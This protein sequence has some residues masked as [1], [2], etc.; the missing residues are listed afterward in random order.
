MRRPRGQ[1]GRFL[2]LEERA[3]LGESGQGTPEIAE[4]GSGQSI[5]QVKA[6]SINE[7]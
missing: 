2:T 5:D 7:E 6:E 4:E 1:G 3:A